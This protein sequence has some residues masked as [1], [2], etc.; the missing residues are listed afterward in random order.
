VQDWTAIMKLLLGF[1][2]AL[3]ACAVHGARQ[4]EVA[5]EIVGL[6]SQK[7]AA[8]AQSTASNRALERA[9]WVSKPDALRFTLTR[10][11]SG[12]ALKLF[13][14][15]TAVSGL[16]P[17]IERQ[18]PFGARAVVTVMRSA[19]EQ[20]A[21]AQRKGVHESASAQ[22]LDLATAQLRADRTI[23]TKAIAESAARDATT[24]SGTLTIINYTCTAVGQEV[25]V[26][27]DVA[28]T[29]GTPA[30]AP[31]KAFD[32]EREEVESE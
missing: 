30:S 12:D 14:P 25:T 13:A 7:N 2:L 19:D 17:K 10:S 22:G 8:L 18:L 16:T 24:V 23:L 6:S 11:P 15:D 31:T 9:A 26:T 1:T 32:V 28:V 21:L 4:P 5:L 27:A 3:E 20:R 29:F